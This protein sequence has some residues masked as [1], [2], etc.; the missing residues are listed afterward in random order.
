M[1][2]GWDPG[3]V[4]YSIESIL[5]WDSINTVNDT[6]NDKYAPGVNH[7]Q[8]KIVYNQLKIV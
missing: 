3:G 2:M 8:L 4:R 6:I 5:A 1:G 7:T